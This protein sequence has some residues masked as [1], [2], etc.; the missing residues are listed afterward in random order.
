MSKNA[1]ARLKVQASFTLVE[2][3]VIDIR[4]RRPYRAPDAPVW[5]FLVDMAIALVMVAIG[6]WLFFKMRGG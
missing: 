1:A 2:A 3:Q 6:A 4:T 5:P